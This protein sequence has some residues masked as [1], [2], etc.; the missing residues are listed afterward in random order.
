MRTVI[1]VGLLLLVVVFQAG[2]VSARRASGKAAKALAGRAESLRSLSEDVS[3]LARVDFGLQA[4]SR[5]S[6][7][8]ILGEGLGTFLHYRIADPRPGFPVM[9]NSYLNTV[10]KLGLLGLLPFLALYALFLKRIWFVYRHA[11]DEFQMLCAA[12]TFVAFVML[13]ILGVESGV[14]VVYRFNL[15]WAALMGIFERWAYQIRQSA[16]EQGMEAVPT[17]APLS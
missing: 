4:V 6:R 10:W 3:L 17:S 15:L 8:P 11:R 12:G 13:I 2:R 16:K 5:W 9:D 14:L 1:A 7:N